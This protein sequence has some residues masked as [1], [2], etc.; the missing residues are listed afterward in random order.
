MSLQSEIKAKLI[1]RKDNGWK[2]F[3]KENGASA[4]QSAFSEL[5]A[6]SLREGKNPISKD[7]LK[8]LLFDGASIQEIDVLMRLK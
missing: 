5:V 4:I 1:N 3:V 6:T 2:D 8:S 7:L